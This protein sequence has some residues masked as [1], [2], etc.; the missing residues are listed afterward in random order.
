ME[1]AEPG[2][3]SNV[4]YTAVHVRRDGLSCQRHVPIVTTIVFGVTISYQ[5]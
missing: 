1:V 3:Y 2:V 4:Q 5:T